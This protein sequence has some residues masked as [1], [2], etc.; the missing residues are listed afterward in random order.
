M[1]GAGRDEQLAAGEVG[2]RERIRDTRWIEL[3][4]ELLADQ[5]A[6]RAVIIGLSRLRPVPVTPLSSVTVPACTAP[7]QISTAAQLRVTTPRRPT[8]PSIG[9]EPVLR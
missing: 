9:A 3:V 6:P 4:V 5:K 2:R 7:A 1:R 8:I